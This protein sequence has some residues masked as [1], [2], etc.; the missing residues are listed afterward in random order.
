[1]KSKIAF[2][3]EAGKLSA[4]IFVI[5]TLIGAAKTQLTVTRATWKLSK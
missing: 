1:M 4:Y 2:A 5:G 3:K